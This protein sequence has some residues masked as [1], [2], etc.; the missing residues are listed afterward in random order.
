MNCELPYVTARANAKSTL[1]GKKVVDKFNTILDYPS[2]TKEANRF[3]QYAK[4]N[5]LSNLPIT[6]RLI[7]SED[8]KVIF[9]EDAFMRI[10]AA[11]GVV[12][13][14][15]EKYRN[16]FNE[17]TSDVFYQLSST[18]APIKNINEQLEEFLSQFGF[19]TEQVFDLKNLTPYSI[20]GATDFL[21]KIIFVQKDK[22]KDA[23]TKEA[24][25]VIFNLLGKKNLLRKDLIASIHLIDGYEQLK[26]VYANSKLS[27]YQIRELIAIDYLQLKLIEAHKEV[28]KT[29]NKAVSEDVVAKNKLDYVIL[30][31]KQWWSN[32]VR[33]FLKSYKKGYIEDVFNQIANDVINNNTRLFNLS[34]STT[35]S[36]M[37]LYGKFKEINTELVKLGAINSGSYSLNKQGTLSRVEINDLDY[38]VP[39]K[40]KDKF[41]KDLIEKYP[42]AKFGKPFTGVM[43]NRSVTISVVIDDIKIDF[44]LPTT[45]QESDNNKIIEIDGTQYHYWKNIFDAKIRIGSKKHLSDLAG[46]IPFVKNKMFYERLDI[47]GQRHFNFSFVRSKFNNFVYGSNVSVSKPTTPTEY[48]RKEL[49]A[50]ATNF[51]K[52]NNINI[53]NSLQY[54]SLLD[55]FK[56]DENEAKISYFLTFSEN[57]TKFFGKNDSRNAFPKF[58]VES[59]SGNYSKPSIL[60]DKNGEPI[61][62]YHGAGTKFDKF[63]KDYFLSGEGAMAYGAGFYTTNF[64]PT[65]DNYRDTSKTA[66]ETYKKLLKENNEPL[67]NLLSKLNI[68]LTEENIDKLISGSD[69]FEIEETERVSILNMLGITE[70]KALYISL[71]NPLYWQEDILEENKKI[72]EEY[73]EVSL[74]N[75]NSGK[76]YRELQKKL[77][78]TDVELSAR[79]YQIGIDGVVK[80]AQGGSAMGGFSHTLGETHVIFFESVQAKSVNNSGVFSLE[81]ENTY[82]PLDKKTLTISESYEQN[83]QEKILLQKED[84]NK[85]VTEEVKQQLISFL[86]T[87][88]PNFKVESIEGL[89]Y[90]GLLNLKEGLIQ[91]ESGKELIALPEEVA[92]VF[93]EL[94]PDTHWAK[95]EMLDKIRNTPLYKETYEAYKDIYTKDGKPDI[96]KI[97]KEAIGKAIAQKLA[98]QE[99]NLKEHKS[100]LDKII[101]SI[102]KLLSK[103]W[104]QLDAFSYS[105]DKILSQD[106]SDLSDTIESGVFYQLSQEQILQA[107]DSIE[108]QADKKQLVSLI[109]KAVARIKSQAKASR[110]EGDLG[111]IFKNNL[112]ELRIPVDL[113]SDIRRW[114]QDQTVDSRFEQSLYTWIKSLDEVSDF[115]KHASSTDFEA[116]KNQEEDVAIRELNTILRIGDGWLT[117]VQDIKEFL[118]EK[119]VPSEG[120]IK[121]FW[122]LLNEVEKSIGDSNLRIRNVI[123]QVI[124]KKIGPLFEESNQ[125]IRANAKTEEDLTHLMTE[126]KVMSYF[127]GRS[128]DVSAFESMFLVMENQK[129]P[130]LASMYKVL[131][132][133]REKYRLEASILNSD[134]AQKINPLLKDLGDREKLELTE[135]V[136]VVTTRVEDGEIITETHKE[137]W[138]ISEHDPKWKNELKKREDLLYI[139]KQRLEQEYNKENLDQYRKARLDLEKWKAENMYQEYSDEYYSE[140]LA[141]QDETYFDILDIQTPLWNQIGDLQELFSVDS[142]PEEKE[143][144]K[145]Q[146]SSLRKKVLEIENLYKPDGSEKEGRER[147]LALKA[148]EKSEFNRKYFTYV[149][150]KRGDITLFEKVLLGKFVEVLETVPFTD[151]TKDSVTSDLNTILDQIREQP[152]KDREFELDYRNL[153]FW[154]QKLPDE[155]SEFKDWVEANVRTQ[156]TDEFFTK[157]ARIL[158]ELKEISNSTV[159]DDRYQLAEEIQF[160]IDNT[161]EKLLSFAR[162]SKGNDGIPEG[163]FSNEE[164]QQ[165]I[166]NF[167]EQLEKL[168]KKLRD[169]KA[170]NKDTKIRIEELIQELE[171]LQERVYTLDYVNEFSS[172]LLGEG[173]QKNFTA[174]TLDEYVSSE[175]FLEKYDYFSKDFKRWF[176]R[177]HFVGYKKIGDS[178][179]SYWK[180]TLLWTRVV[181][182]NPNDYWYLPKS[183]YY[184]R[185]IRK[186][187]EVEKKEGVNVD[188]LGNWLPKGFK[189]EKW[190][191]LSPKKKEL[192]KKVTDFYLENQKGMWENAPGLRVPSVSKKGLEAGYFKDLWDSLFNRKNRFEEG[193]GNVEELKPK[194]FKESFKERFSEVVTRI[195]NIFETG[196]LGVKKVRTG[197]NGEVFKEIPYGYTAIMDPEEVTDDII[198]AVSLFVTKKSETKAHIAI[199]PFY[200]IVD[201]FLDTAVKDPTKVSY[202]K[203]LNG[204]EQNAKLKGNTRLDRFREF[205]DMEVYG[206]NRAYEATQTVDQALNATKRIT[207]FV[208]QSILSPVNNTKNYLAGSLNNLIQSYISTKS[209]R[210]AQVRSKS[211]FQFM[212]QMTNEAKGFDFQLIKLFNIGNLDL[213]SADMYNQL[214]MA[215]RQNLDIIK[216]LGQGLGE[217]A[218]NNQIVYG[219]LLDTKVKYKGKV[220]S[221]LE[222]LEENNKGI[223]NVDFNVEGIEY[224][225]R[226]M[227]KEDLINLKLKMSTIRTNVQGLPESRSIAER[228][229]IWNAVQFFR[230]YLIP[231]L[232]QRFQ[233]KRLN[234][235]LETQQEGYYITAIKLLSAYKGNVLAIYKEFNNLTPL[236]QVNALRFLKELAVLMSILLIQFLLGYDE[237]DP[238]KN[239][240]IRE[241]NNSFAG[242][243]INHLLLQTIMVYNEISSLSTLPYGSGYL[244]SVYSETLRN[245]TTTTIL[246]GKFKQIRDLIDSFLDILVHN[247]QA[248]YSKNMPYY[249]IKTG[250]YKFVEKL[251]K[252]TGFDIGSPVIDNGLVNDLNNPA[253]RIYVLHQIMNQ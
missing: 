166:K 111:G 37:E 221:L 149:Q 15:N 153:F 238:D 41:L 36:K 122:D 200:N 69:F 229:T 116:V 82:D 249:N 93:V 199:T 174:D 77:N 208:S 78:I 144:I 70:T 247:E 96:E 139:Y 7:T 191:N 95:K 150:S 127:E 66:I 54:K 84:T 241:R 193:E 92:H 110:I 105:V 209:W 12:Y 113:Q 83:Q 187:Y 244:P 80:I 45:Q 156:N 232:Y 154:S 87:V 230:R 44:F 235:M 169:T 185:K 181:A 40:I 162:Q 161:Y 117:Y 135:V 215:L 47:R 220:K 168:K 131:T 49:I 108:K 210:E 109:D 123:K 227:T 103:Y 128:G 60:R 4:D 2:F 239:R 76:I 53:N 242:K 28:L 170:Y 121:P 201:R 194:N 32:I 207:S 164:E 245:V 73:F 11:K 160:E 119:G 19:S 151:E 10:D 243:M 228:Y 143:A 179:E 72:I 23:Y 234:L 14:A 51:F 212:S 133:Y 79:L 61:V 186:E 198:G 237:D 250:D 102:R 1:L 216:Y 211:Y 148:K 246:M 20:I 30:K 59:V 213:S 81:N 175:E 120:D 8:N 251:Q 163:R 67:L 5:Y 6:E 118:L 9:N 147:E 21:E 172:Y 55:Y 134:F 225:G 50:V 106:V 222:A 180:P 89:G 16:D 157:R 197:F 35:Y 98:G 177:N 43:G 68:T 27:D 252:F 217:F 171:E 63:S 192:L 114:K 224:N 126:D 142:T 129:D 90:N 196:S 115:F 86:K 39:Y 231:A 42:Q 100:L 219:V 57:F 167:E 99:P 64:K 223:S 236:E 33:R 46:F 141:L 184:R 48:T 125:S 101:D 88:N 18:R 205:V 26:S 65:A 56:G 188:K 62:F 112:G 203:D 140:K 145:S 75:K 206:D 130:V 71:T 204:N 182:K 25:F 202:S 74:E 138:L 85:A 240:K 94:L 107:K 38:F 124:W 24:A 155:F 183:E 34:K 97:K 233:T 190:N 218:I 17:F 248:T 104:K 152:I 176:E 159:R 195:S 13:P 136:D 253:G 22:I 178:Y 173:I 137:K 132:Q 189:S 146:I 3:W 214:R 31:I 58:I 158:Q 226:E 165:T 91:L 29:S 52:K